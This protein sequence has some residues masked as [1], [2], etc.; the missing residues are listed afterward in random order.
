MISACAWVPRG[1]ARREPVRH[2][3]SPGEAAA[4]RAQAAAARAGDAERAG[5]GDDEEDLI[6]LDD[7]DEVEAASLSPAH[8]VAARRDVRPPRAARAQ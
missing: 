3:L 8:F 2:E 1:A 4:L 6:A 7:V 5:A